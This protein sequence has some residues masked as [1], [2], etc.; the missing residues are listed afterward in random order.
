MGENEYDEFKDKYLNTL[1]NLTL[2]GNNGS[3]GNKPFKAKRDLPDKGY[4]DSRLFLNKYLPE[5]AL[6]ICD[7][8]F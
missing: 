6:R 5:H 3:L 8:N 4:K 2:S 7:N 1:A